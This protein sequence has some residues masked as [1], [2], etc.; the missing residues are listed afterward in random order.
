MASERVSFAGGGYVSPFFDE[1]RIAAV[2]STLAEMV[3]PDHTVLEVGAGAGN[4]SLI[5]AQYAKRVIAVED[6]E[7]L[8]AIFAAMLER[9]ALAHVE[10]MKVARLAD[11]KPAEQVDILICELLSPALLLQPQAPALNGFLKYLKPGGAVV[12]HGITNMITLVQSDFAP[13]GIPFRFP[14]REREDLTV[15]SPKTAATVLNQFAFAEGLPDDVQE[16]V[17]VTAIAGGI[18]NAVRI[19]SVVN[20]GPDRAIKGR[21]ILCTPIVVPLSDD[22]M[23]AA[24]QQYDVDIAYQHATD[25]TD[26][27]KFAASIRPVAARAPLRPD[28]AA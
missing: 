13:Y 14:Y 11:F 28:V 5:A 16:T 3:K 12:P 18:C 4:I 1:E 7:S 9:S 19:E 20:I 8:N 25:L 26:H 15:S 17:S 23:L 10:L 27:P 24:G 6:D 21:P 2:D 22:V